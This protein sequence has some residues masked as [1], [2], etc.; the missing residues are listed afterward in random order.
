MIDLP[1]N[2]ELDIIGRY[3][4]GLPKTTATEE[5]RSYG[6]VDARLAWHYKSFEIS[7]NGQNLLEKYHAEFGSQRI[8][9]SVYGKVTCRL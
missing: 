4:D 1:A 8:P 3:V 6:T 2:F 7:L 5:V 9:R